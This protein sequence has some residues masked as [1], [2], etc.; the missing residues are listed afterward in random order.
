MYTRSTRG[1][2]YCHRTDRYGDDHKRGIYTYITSTGESRSH[3]MFQ[4]KRSTQKIY[5]IFPRP[6]YLRYYLTQTFRDWELWMVYP[7]SDQ[8]YV[9]DWYLSKY[10]WDYLEYRKINSWHLRNRDRTHILCVSFRYFIIVY[11]IPHKGGSTSWYR[12]SAL[13]T[14]HENRRVFLFYND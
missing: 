11:I 9:R 5:R 6:P 2:Q 1:A 4:R 13:A 14:L 7:G 8:T 12:I 10:W 3:R